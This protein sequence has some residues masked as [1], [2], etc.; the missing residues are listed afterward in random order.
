MI[1]SSC[2]FSVPH[3]KAPP[4]QL[5]M[6]CAKPLRYHVDDFLLHGASA[7]VREVRPS[8]VSMGR[9]VDKALQENAVA[10]MEGPVG[11]HAAGQ[12]ILMYDGTLKKVEDVE[13]G[14]QLMGP[15]S[16]P[17]RVLELKRGQQEMVDVVP[18]KGKRWRVNLDHVLTFVRSGKDTIHDVTVREY[19]SWPPAVRGQ[20]KL[21]R[22]GVEF[23]HTSALPIDP[24]FLG[25]LLG[26]GS[27]SRRSSVKVVTK[28]P[29]IIQ[30]LEQEALAR[31]LTL[32]SRGIE[33][34]LTRPVESRG[35]AP[36]LLVQQLQ[37][38]KLWPVAC[39]ERFIPDMYKRASR[40]ERLQL[41]AGLIDTDGHLYKTG[42]YN[43]VSKSLPLADDVTFL[44]RSLGFAA[45]C[46]EL[47][48]SAYP[49]HSDVYRRVNIAGDVEQIPCRIARKKAS[50][51]KLKRS[52]LRTGFTLAPTGQAEAFY[53]FTLD[54]DGRYVLE[55]FTIT[56]NSGKS[57]S[58]CVPSI[59]SGNRIVVS[60]AKKQ[61]QHQLFNKDL[62]Y[63]TSRMGVAA[64]YALLKGKSNYA[65][66]VKVRDIPLAEQDAF[67]RWL[68]ESELGDLTDYPGKRPFFWGDVTAEDCLGAACK[69]Q[70]KCGYFKSKQQMKAARV[71]IANHHVVAFDLRFGPGKILGPYDTLIID[72]AHQAPAAFRSAYA[73]T[74]TP[75]S[76]KRII[77]KLDKAGVAQGLDKPLEAAWADMFARVEGLDGEVP[78]NPFGSAGDHAIELLEM[79]SREVTKELKENGFVEEGSNDEDDEAAAPA[80][81]TDWEAVANLKM[82]KG[83]IERPYQALT[84]ARQPDDNTVVYISSSGEMGKFKTVNVAP[85]NVG[86]IIGPK[87]AQLQSVIVT[88]ATIAVG[89][90]FDDIVNQL[91][92]DWKPPAASSQ[93][94]TQPVSLTQAVQSLAAEGAVAERKILTGVFESPFDYNRQA[95][96]YTP[97][98]L[99]LPVG[100]G[101]FEA[102]REKYLRLL[103]QE[104]MKLIR[105]SD[106]NAFILF[107]S[108][109][110]MKEVAQRLEEEDLPNPLLVQ[111]DDAEATFK[112]F[113]KTP[114]SVILGLKSF[115]EGVDVQGDKLRLVVITKLPFPMVSDPVNK[116]RE[117]QLRAQALARGMS[118]AAAGNTVFQAIQIPQMITDLR[119]GAGRLI[120]SKTD[121]GVLAILDARI[122]TGS[123]RNGPTPTQNEYRGYGKQAVEA[124]GFGQRTSSFDI[125]DKVLQQ[126]RREEAQRA[127]KAQGSA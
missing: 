75:N 21:M 67:Y 41:L 10:I 60:T 6:A 122:W 94:P 32:S 59:L 107:T 95:L 8:Q 127:A 16:T 39:H 74:I 19:L 7:L 33:Y 103:S 105:A 99:P 109:L 117:R 62:P 56:H 111:G 54:G 48:C 27:L 104:C 52:T 50:P 96:L 85:I 22:T 90:K 73:A 76:V 82:L 120:R 92:L 97:K 12:G 101:P 14:D 44:A 118:E 89:G 88:S 1:C 115:W 119:Q 61:L 53:G 23:G 80:Q 83:A 71:I 66:R 121:K 45:Y 25:V 49:G 34:S 70:K 13:V 31:G 91:G 102:E 55:D 78:A 47:R 114:R 58:Y 98:H 51:R 63:L 125:V 11:C 65:C 4:D 37:A 57:F 24:Y 69:H 110:D 28:D 26:D 68:D 123:S 36:H 64:Q 9:L 116:A 108:S 113:M 35:R 46:K 100:P 124:I 81:V 3:H 18:R 112:Q 42:G 77:R 40:N 30:S 87:L 5:C 38:L 93:P 126:L 20:C 29:E 2:G 15:D 79:L 84:Q 72:E 106:G 86:R 17:R 43:F